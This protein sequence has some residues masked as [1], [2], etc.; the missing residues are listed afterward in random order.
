MLDGTVLLRILLYENIIFHTAPQDYK[1][2]NMKGF[3]IH[4][5]AGKTVTYLATQLTPWYY[6]NQRTLMF[7]SSGKLTIACQPLS[8]APF[9]NLNLDIVALWM[10]CPIRYSAAMHAVW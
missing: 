3:S 10:I 5:T 8:S 9:V 2:L 1:T 7:D 6:S 4:L